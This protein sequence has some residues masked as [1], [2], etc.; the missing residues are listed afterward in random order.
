MNYSIEA[1]VETADLSVQNATQ[2]LSRA[3]D[4]QRG[5][6]KKICIL[7]VVLAI[8]GVVIGLII[9]GAIKGLRLSCDIS[10]TSEAHRRGVVL[11]VSVS[12]SSQRDGVYPRTAVAV[13]KK[14]VCD[15]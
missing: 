8:A 5:S 4:Y 2:Q 9:W 11:G 1:N 7:V 3:A 6:R 12:E 10:G 14:G 15:S 13:R